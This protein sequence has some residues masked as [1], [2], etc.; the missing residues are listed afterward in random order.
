[1]ALNMIEKFNK[2]WLDVND[3]MGVA[4]VL[5]PRFKHE[6]L[7]FYFPKIYDKHNGH[8]VERILG[9]CHQ[10][11]VEY[12]E[13][14]REEEQGNGVNGGGSEANDCEDSFALEFH[15]YASS[16]K[17]KRPSRSELDAYLE[18]E[19]IKSVADFD[20]LSW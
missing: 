16:K 10:R 12:E 14:E 18:D 5:D 8:E 3:L 9:L 2:Y 11:V 6:V 19:L 7:Q 1:M 4:V 17:R 15:S 13:K 20:L